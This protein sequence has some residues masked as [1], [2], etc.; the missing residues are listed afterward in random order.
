[1]AF[2]VL[3]ES[4]QVWGQLNPDDIETAAAA[5]ITC[6]INNRPDGEEPGQPNGDDLQAIA[7][8]KGITWVSVP[9]I[10]GQMSMTEVEG[11][12]AALAGAKGP[13]LAYCRTGTRTTNLWGLATAFTKQMQPDDI[14]NAAKGAGYDLAPVYPILQ[15]L[16]SA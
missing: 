10:P 15:Q 5:G 14:M 3:T 12:A 4:L 7:E 1:M 8:D 13:V 9:V 2:K 11:M 6:I 16:Y